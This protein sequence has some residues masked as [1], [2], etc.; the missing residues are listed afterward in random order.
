MAPTNRCS[1]L[2]TGKLNQKSHHCSECQRPITD[3]CHKQK[4]VA[5]C[6]RSDCQTLF[7]VLTRGGCIKHPYCDGYN[8]AVVKERRGFN[9]DFQNRWQIQKQKEDEEERKAKE[10][11]EKKR[12]EELA[13]RPYDKDWKKAEYREKTPPRESLKSKGKQALAPTV[14]DLKKQRGKKKA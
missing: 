5:Y 6:E 8:A 12:Q 14:N 3:R 2:L 7:N 10:E 11:E 1:N 13:N 9:P 4:H